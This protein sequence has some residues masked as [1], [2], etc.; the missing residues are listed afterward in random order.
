MFA[1]FDEA[2]FFP[3]RKRRRILDAIA[4]FRRAHR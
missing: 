1:L 4:R 2:L 3:R